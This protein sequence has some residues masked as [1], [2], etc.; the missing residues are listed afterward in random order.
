MPRLLAAL[1]CLTLAAG[2]G[3]AA[4]ATRVGIWATAPLEEA[5]GPEL[6]S[7][8]GLVLRQVVRISAGAE[9]LRLR[10]SNEYGSEPLVLEDVRLAVADGGGRIRAQTDRPVL[11]GGAARVSIPPQSVFVSDPLVFPAPAHSDLAITAR[12]LS[13]P[14]KLAGHPGSRATSYLKPGAGTADADLNGATK[15]VHWYFLSGI[16]AEDGAAG[17]SAVVCLGDSITDGR[18]CQPD[19]N[20]RWTDALSRRLRADPATVG[21]S[22]LNL[23][24]GGGRLLRPGLGPSGLARLSRDVFG[25]A[26]VK[27]LILQLGVNDLGTRIKAK[28]AG[29][30]YASAQ[31]IIDGYRQAISACRSRGVL[32]ALATITPFAGAAWYSTPE[33][34]ADRQA[35]NRWIREAA[36]C[37]RVID[38]DAALRDPAQPTLLLP[39]YDSGDHLHPSMAG[40]ERM[41]ES[42]PLDFF[43]PARPGAK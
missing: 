34:E 35:I 18:G 5:A 25:Q 11:F 8:Q 20:T 30:A 36:P 2:A 15:I 41:A 28:P 14:Q 42:V 32:V 21:V 26:G 31:D 43:I 23:G 13:L 19:E 10:L 16:E 37:D 24:I 33:I 6:L 38:F 9:T 29:Q 1:A 7:G 22:V 4:A 12:L 40:Y 39:A 3:S 17:R 27:W